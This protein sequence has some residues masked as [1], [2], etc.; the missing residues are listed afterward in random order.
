LSISSYTGAG[1]NP[2]RSLCPAIINNCWKT[3]S[4]G[5]TFQWVYPL[6]QLSGGA[7]AGL[8]YMMV[9]LNRPDDGA[10][11]AAANSFRFMSTETKALKQRLEQEAGKKNA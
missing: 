7:A 1:L 6:A 11:S 3:A 10:A 5:D 4:F 2:A 9:F 8:V